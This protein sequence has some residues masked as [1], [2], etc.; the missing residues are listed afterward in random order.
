MT[1]PVSSRMQDA[2]EISSRP[3]FSWTG[4]LFLMP[5]EMEMQNRVMDMIRNA[6]SRKMFC[7]N[8]FSRDMVMA[9]SELR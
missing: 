9:F 4:L 1:H 2:A 3:F 7:G 8:I 5:P 6:G